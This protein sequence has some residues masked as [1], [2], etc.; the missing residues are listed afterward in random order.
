MLNVN[1]M[2]QLKQM[3]AFLCSWNSRLI[4]CALDWELEETLIVPT[5]ALIGNIEVSIRS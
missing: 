2:K 4:Y 5:A 3:K 1:T